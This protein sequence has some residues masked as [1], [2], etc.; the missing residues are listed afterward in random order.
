MASVWT[1][2]A[3]RL[4][5]INRIH[6]DLGLIFQCLPDGEGIF[7]VGIVPGSA[8]SESQEVFRGDV[9]TKVNMQT[10]RKLDQ[11]EVDMAFD[12]AGDI[13]ELTISGH[14][15]E[16]AIESALTPDITP[17]SQRDVSCCTHFVRILK[18]PIGIPLMILFFCFAI[19]EAVFHLLWW[20]VQR[21]ADSTIDNTHADPDNM[22]FDLMMA[23]WYTWIMETGDYGFMNL[24]NSYGSRGMQL[25]IQPASLGEPAR[26]TALHKADSIRVDK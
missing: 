15:S 12:S 11:R 1:R 25:H 20:W 16:D 17:E 21:L 22:F 5:R 3:N 4:A 23:I 6:A 24:S 26:I 14:I 10:L 7:I 2:R 19:V 9:V 13:L 8:A 18:C